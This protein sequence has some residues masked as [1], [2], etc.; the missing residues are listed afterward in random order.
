MAPIVWGAA[1]LWRAVP[2]LFTTTL[3]TGVALRV[4][5]RQRLLSSNKEPQY[6]H[7]VAIDDGTKNRI[8]AYRVSAARYE[9]V[10]QGEMLTAEINPRLG[11]VRTWR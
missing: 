9:D 5:M 4:R 10:H 8:T 2:D 11:H 3:V 1:V 7:Y 6:H